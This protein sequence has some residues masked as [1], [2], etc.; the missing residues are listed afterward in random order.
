MM[1]DRGALGVGQSS[2]GPA[3]YGVVRGEEAAAGLAAV[4]RDALG[5]AGTVYEGSFRPTG[6]R[7]WRAPLAMR[8]SGG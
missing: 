5:G 3:V 7:V 8:Q 4:V 1:R 2:W 6:A